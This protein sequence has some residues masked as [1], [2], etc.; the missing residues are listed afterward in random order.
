[1]NLHIQKSG[2]GSK[3]FYI[4]LGACLIAVGVAAWTTYDSVVNYAAPGPEAQSSSAAPANNT[5][6]GVY[7]SEPESSS[8]QAAVSSS[9]KPE[10]SS[11]AVVSSKPAPSSKAPAKQASAKVWTYSYPVDKT[12]AQKFSEDPVFCEATGDWR[13]HTG[14]DLSAKTDDP[15]K[16]IADGKVTRTYIDDRYGSTAVIQHGSV[17]AWYCGLG[18]TKIRAGEAVTAG[19][20]IGTV[21]IVPIESAEGPH[22]HLVLK[23]NGKYVDPLTLLQ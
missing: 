13:A 2:K 6:S 17:E 11:Q 14:I 16:A 15:V 8:S 3:G 22:L 1:M 18:D 4:A 19:Q 9:S 10:S 21:G 5:V 7:V 12:I 23:E 20:Q